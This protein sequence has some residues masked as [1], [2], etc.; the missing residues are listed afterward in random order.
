MKITNIESHCTLIEREIKKHADR[1]VK[2]IFV[3][4]IAEWSVVNCPN[5][6][7]NP[8]AMAINFGQS[9]EWGIVFRRSSNQHQIRGIISGIE[10]RIGERRLIT[11]SR[12]L[13]HLVLHELAH[14]A[15]NW[16]QSMEAECDQWA[17][18]R[19]ST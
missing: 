2:L 12:F 6:Q 18:D 10:L 5:A 14:L 11:L 4:D 19:L 8:I 17:S 16:D 9:K 1:S 13:R 3:D 15:N 7:G